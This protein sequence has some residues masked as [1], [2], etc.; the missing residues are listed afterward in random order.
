MDQI[1]QTTGRPVARSQSNLFMPHR[2]V[3]D[4]EV[5]LIVDDSPENLSALGELLQNANYH[6]K[7]ANSGQTALRLAEHDPKPA[8]ILLDIMM[9][10]M[11][12]HD[13]MRSLRANMATCTIPVI[14]I[15]SKIDEEEEECAFDAGVSDYIVKPFKP[16]VILA[17]IRNQL[18]VSHA[19][20]WL[21][22]QNHALEAEVELRMSENE[23]IQAISIQAL[24]RLAETRDNE[25]GAHLQRTQSYVRLL[26][27]RLST[28]PR[29][30]G[31]LN[32]KYIDM[33][34]RSAPLHD[35]G[36]VGIPDRILLKPG[37]LDPDEWEVMKTHTVV[38]S[39]AI[40]MA[41]RDMGASAKYLLQAKEI[42]R[43]HH[44]RWDGR[45][46]PDGLWGENIPVS[47]RLMALADVFDALISR[48]AYKEAIPFSD[49]RAIISG[50][51][52]K[53]FDPDVVDTFLDGW[54]DFEKIALHFGIET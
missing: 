14:F 12:G 27:Q 36:K 5:I 45:G 46:Y 52:G 40:T 26:A 54:S 34:S 20:R 19:R 15:T 13:V 51:R 11:D 48:R 4:G 1:V 28:H 37:K 3:T 10:E 2:R 53:H 17:R 18:L 22:D 21:Q 7:V 30:S 42:A 43:W 35:I 31:M 33:L 41:E 49:V 24:A 9:P 47:P 29:F 23:Q 44:E 25:T 38:G 50:E 8:L 16:S 32:G 39:E 6:V